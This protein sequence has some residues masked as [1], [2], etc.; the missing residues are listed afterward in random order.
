MYEVIW[1]DNINRVLDLMLNQSERIHRYIT[2]L[3]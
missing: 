2:A 1:R 3:D